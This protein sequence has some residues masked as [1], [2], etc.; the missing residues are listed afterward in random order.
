MMGFPKI[1]YI[2]H[3]NGFKII[4]IAA[5]R[6]KLTNWIYIIFYP[7]SFLVTWLVYR[8]EEKEKLQRGVNRQ[9][10]RA[11]FSRSVF[12]GETIIIKARK[13]NDLG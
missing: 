5:N 2:L 6:I 8:K 10:L 9:I 1:R 4:R 11:M 3:T 12:F 7:F 13:Q